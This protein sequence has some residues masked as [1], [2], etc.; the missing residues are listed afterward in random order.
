MSTTALWSGNKSEAVLS[1]SRENEL[2]VVVELEHS[3]EAWPTN[4]TISGWSPQFKFNQDPCLGKI[5]ANTNAHFHCKGFIFIP[6]YLAPT[7]IIFSL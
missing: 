6:Y 1:R 7:L 2:L 4:R 5:I 3:D